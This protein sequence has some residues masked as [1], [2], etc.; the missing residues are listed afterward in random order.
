VNRDI[1]ASPKAHEDSTLLLSPGHAPRTVHENSSTRGL[2]PVRSLHLLSSPSAGNRTL[3]ASPDKATIT[4]GSF[5]VAHAQDAVSVPFSPQGKAKRSAS[6]TKLDP[7][8]SPPIVASP[9]P[10]R[11]PISPQLEGLSATFPP[12]PVGF[13]A[14]VQPLQQFLSPLPT[15]HTH[16]FRPSPVKIYSAA[17]TRLTMPEFQSSPASPSYFAEGVCQRDLGSVVVITCRSLPLSPW[18]AVAGYVGAG[19]SPQT[20]PASSGGA[21]PMRLQPT[22][23]KRAIKSPGTRHDCLALCTEEDVCCFCGSCR[24]QRPRAHPS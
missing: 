2:S 3:N 1:L 9:E 22:H 4:A 8:P 23:A 18:C 5:P 20:R 16:S 15:A 13:A 21:S 10:A 14:Q 7:L 11:L 19:R 17:N 12:R 6:M 24:P